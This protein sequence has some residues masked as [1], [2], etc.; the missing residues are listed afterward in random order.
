MKFAIKNKIVIN[1]LMICNIIYEANN[2]SKLKLKHMFS[3]MRSS[4]FKCLKRCLSTQ[5]IMK[6]PELSY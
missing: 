5:V 3:L 6:K 4:E 1:V 2:K